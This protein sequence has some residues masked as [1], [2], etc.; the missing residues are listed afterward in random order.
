MQSMSVK[1]APQ[2]FHTTHCTYDETVSPSFSSCK[3]YLPNILSIFPFFWKCKFL[4]REFVNLEFLS[5]IY[6]LESEISVNVGSIFGIV[7][8]PYG[9]I[10]L[11]VEISLWTLQVEPL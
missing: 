3:P 10:F 7:F 8:S 4:Q 6:N 1:V 5:T 2:I 11:S 9:G